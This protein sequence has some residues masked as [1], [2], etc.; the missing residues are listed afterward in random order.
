[1]R[2][3]AASSTSCGVVFSDPAPDASTPTGQDNNLD[4]TQGAFSDNGSTLTTTLTV[5]D[6]STT[7]TQTAE[8][9]YYMVFPYNGTDY[10][11]EVD[12]NAAGGV[13][14]SYGTYSSTTGYS[15]VGTATGSFNPGS[16]GTLTVNLPF[17]DI[18]N[19]L[20][21]GDTLSQNG[22]FGEAGYLAGG[23]VE[24]SGGGVVESADND[25]ASSSYT[26]GE[27]NGATTSP[28]PSPSPPPARRRPPR[29][30]PPPVVA[31]RR[32]AHR[33]APSSMSPRMA[34]SARSLFPA[35]TT[36]SPPSSVTTVPATTV[37]PGSS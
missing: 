6:L 19:N 36:P 1:M 18:A 27:C 15:G 35:T 31:D 7:P 14:Y 17:A 24:G 25:T 34:S 23:T 22:M 33:R 8:D 30:P 20:T 9:E 29:R 32:P 4:L 11:T 37:C 28:S 10:Y 2:A 26:I 3:A 16:N 13:T 12:N 21:T 5:I